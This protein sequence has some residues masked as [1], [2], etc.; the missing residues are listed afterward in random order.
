[1]GYHTDFDGAFKLSKKL[2][3]AQFNF[4]KMFAETRRMPRDPAKVEA[5]TGEHRNGECLRLLKV[6]NLPLTFYC[7]TGFAGQD[8]DASIMDYNGFDR[9]TVQPFPGLWCQWV[10][11]EHKDIRGK[12]CQYL[13][14][15][16]GEKFYNY[17][18]WLH[19]LIDNFF[20]PWGV[21]LTGEVKWRGDDEY[22]LG[23]IQ[24]VDNEV[25]VKEGR[26]VYE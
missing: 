7:G 5:L 8:S 19:F 18:E 14:W 6:L 17:V 4:L 1:M 24:V 16:G 10:P 25:T 13:E 2:T 11:T 20:E 12:S 22:D 15:D 23:L 3:T 21:K 9:N 26:I